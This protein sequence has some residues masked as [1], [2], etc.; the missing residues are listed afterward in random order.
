MNS[1]DVRSPLY[2]AFADDS[3]LADLIDLFAEEMPLKTVAMQEAFNEGTRELLVRLAHQLKG[4]AG[5][6]GFGAINR[7]ASKL[8]SSLRSSAPAKVISD[9]LTELI[10]VC[11][12][13]RPIAPCEK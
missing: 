4:S 7:F 2:S 13:V 1:T 6:Y 5:S 9:Q 11:A 3:D 12:Q 10:S 8:E